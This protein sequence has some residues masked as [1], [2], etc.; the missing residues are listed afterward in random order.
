MAER[1]MFAKTIIDSDAFLDM[2]LSTQVLYFHL[3]MRA[4]DDGFINN[5]KKIQR[6]IGASED[7]LK[8]LIAKNFIIPFESGIVVIKHWKI[9]NYIRNDRKKGT[10]YREEM[11]LLNSKENGAYTLND[12]IPVIECNDEKETLR[13]KAYKESSLPYSFSYKIRNAFIGKRCPI[14]NCVMSNNNNLVRPTMQH[15]I[16]ISKGGLHELGNIS[17]ICS[18]CNSSIKDNETDEMNAEEV[19]EVWD[20]ICQ[21]SD[22]Q[23]TDKWDTQVR[24]GKDRLEL[25]LGKDSIDDSIESPPAKTTKHKYGEYNNVLL[26]DEELQKLKTE[27]S[28][29]EERIERLSSYVAS[30]GKKYKSHYATIRNWARKDATVKPISRPT[31]QK[32]TKADELDDFYKMASAWA[33]GGN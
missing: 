30:T 22:R 27:Y 17:I 18:S 4:D 33:E 20:M 25:E 6:M 32:Q 1:R 15:N 24:L 14:C 21:T 10:V 9:H 26:T 19:I 29:F 11:S 31:Y 7:D 8:L 16:P 28:D 13:Q 3:N 5:P 12:E 2:P 23:V